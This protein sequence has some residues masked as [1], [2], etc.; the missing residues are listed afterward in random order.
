MKV[1]TDL[2]DLAA[3][4][5]DLIALLRRRRI[6]LAAAR[7]IADA[8]VA[9]VRHY[10]HG[11]RVDD[12]VRQQQPKL[13]AWLTDTLKRVERLR[14][15]FEEDAHCAHPDSSYRYN[16]YSIL[17]W[18]SAGDIE[19]FLTRLDYIRAQVIDH[20][21]RQR[22]M[23]K[24]RPRDDARARLEADIADIL[25]AAGVTLTK[26]K[27]GTLGRV[28]SCVHDEIGA[29]EANRGTDLGKAAR[30]AVASLVRRKLFVSRFLKGRPKG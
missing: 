12:A 13:R 25:D 1:R 23:R 22:P 28:L 9:K 15:R 3:F 10:P 24:G 5:T 7:G 4:R 26:A 30:R 20:A 8:I 16:L 14:D 27:D 21:R 2:V 6:G 19:D 29:A 17:D 18:S 11:K